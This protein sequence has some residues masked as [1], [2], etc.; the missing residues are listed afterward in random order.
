LARREL[1]S[2]YPN[3][4]IERVPAIGSFRIFVQTLV[5]LNPSSEFLNAS[6]GKSVD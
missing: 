1:E 4:R 2:T 6:L 3:A 5:F